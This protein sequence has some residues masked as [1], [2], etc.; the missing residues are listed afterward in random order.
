ML[1]ERAI[2]IDES[3]TS[4]NDLVDI[5]VAPTVDWSEITNIPTEF[6]PEAHTQDWDTIT[7]KPI[8]FPPTNPSFRVVTDTTTEL[9]MDDTII[10]NKASAMTVNL[11]IAL[12]TGRVVTISNINTGIVTVDG[13]TTDTID[14]ELTQAIDQWE[15]LVIQDYAVGK[16]KII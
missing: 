14:G 9:D 1:K 6:P 2:P 5:P 10:C 16:F 15:T 12:G 8:V 3:P 11:L 13:N 7:D 4:Y